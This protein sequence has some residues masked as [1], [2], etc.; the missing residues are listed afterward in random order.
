[1]KQLRFVVSRRK[2]INAEIEG[3][4]IGLQ[5]VRQDRGGT[6]W[7]EKYLQDKLADRKEVLRYMDVFNLL[8]L[9]DGTRQ[10]MTEKQMWKNNSLIRIEQKERQEKSDKGWE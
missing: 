7:E 2:D 9:D 6:G 10:M 8:L 5:A 4:N 3:C 1:M